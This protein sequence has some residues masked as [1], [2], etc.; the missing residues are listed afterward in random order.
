MPQRWNI[1]SRPCRVRLISKGRFSRLPGYDANM[2]VDGLISAFR[3]LKNAA[4]Y[5]RFLIACI[6]NQPRLRPQH[7]AHLFEPHP[8][9][10]V[11]EMRIAGGGLHLRVAEQFADHRQAHAA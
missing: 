5:P 2:D 8:E 9:R 1:S 10:I 6:L 3:G 7:V 11:E 4:V